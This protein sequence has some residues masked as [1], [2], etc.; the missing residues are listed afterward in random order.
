MT[1]RAVMRTGCVVHILDECG[2]YQYGVAVQLSVSE[3][4]S[5]YLVRP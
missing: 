4:S 5:L 3:R 1:V 2:S